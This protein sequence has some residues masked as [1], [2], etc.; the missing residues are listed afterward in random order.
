MTGQ[1]INVDGGNSLRSGPDYGELVVMMHGP[2]AIP[3]ATRPSQRSSS[4]IATV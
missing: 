4:V 2:D 1:I 3:G